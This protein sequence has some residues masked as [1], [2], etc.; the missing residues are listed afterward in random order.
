MITNE[1]SKKIGY[2]EMCL[3]E[4]DIRTISKSYRNSYS[5]V[6][7]SSCREIFNINQHCQGFSSKEEA[8][9]KR[10][11]FEHEEIKKQQ[12][13]EAAQLEYEEERKNLLLILENDLQ[14]KTTVYG[15][16]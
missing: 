9:Q 6:L 10:M 15:R 4:N 14:S 7:F 12:M 16:K 5:V 1:Y 8:L 13:L 11:E 3:A 2:Y